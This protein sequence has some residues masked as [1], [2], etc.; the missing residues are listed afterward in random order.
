MANSI[1]ILSHCLLNQYSIVK[2]G[3]MREGN[4]NLIK[5]LMDMG[6]G[7][8]QLPCPETIIY[9]T[10]RWGQVYEQFDNNFYR[11]ISRSIL[12]PIVDEI[13]DYINDGIKFVGFI[14]IDGSPSCGVN[15]TCSSKKYKGELLDDKSIQDYKSSVEMISSQGVFV[16]ELEKLLEE[17]KIDK[18][19]YGYNDKNGEEI[20]KR[21]SDIIEKI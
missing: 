1:V 5:N 3:Y 20:I 7:I 6:V 8:I 11:K 12:A 10:N 15:L 2:N 13:E 4:L 9:G 17:K 19:F 21:I 14:G 18:N 16:E